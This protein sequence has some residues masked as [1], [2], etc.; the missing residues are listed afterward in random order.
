MVLRVHAVFSISSCWSSPA[1]APHSS[2]PTAQHGCTRLLGLNADLTN[3]SPCLHEQGRA[4]CNPFCLWRKE[5]S[6]E[7]LLH[8]NHF[9]NVRPDSAHP[10]PFAARNAAV[11]LVPDGELPAH[12]CCLVWCWHKP[13]KTV[14]SC[15]LGW[16]L[17][18]EQVKK[19][20]S[21][22]EL[23]GD[24]QE[25]AVPCSHGTSRAVSDA[26]G[27]GKR[28]HVMCHRGRMVKNV[29]SY[30][31]EEVFF[32]LSSFK[33]YLALLTQNSPFR[34]QSRKDSPL[35]DRWS[36]TVLAQPSSLL[37]QMAG[38]ERFYAVAVAGHSP[39]T[40]LSTLEPNRL[41][42]A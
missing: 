39:K 15:L 35:P 21:S 38:C 9:C 28:A 40:E 41:K 42:H 33:L 17:Q 27:S 6:A 20:G 31:P 12:L 5:S 13:G 29:V 36:S 30:L 14:C 18:E 16:E 26:V 11:W 32:L 10:L 25:A 4:K 19:E 1:L 22:Q 37:I 7:A 34:H 3:M 8:L 24:A 2:L 23:S